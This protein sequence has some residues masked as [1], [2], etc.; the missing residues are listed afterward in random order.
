M[1]KQ[2]RNSSVRKGA[3]S[4]EQL[5]HQINSVGVE[6]T[7]SLDARG[8]ATWEKGEIFQRHEKGPMFTLP[9]IATAPWPHR[10]ISK[11]KAE[12]LGRQNC[13]KGRWPA[14]GTEPGF[15]TER[16]KP[17]FMRW[18]SVLYP[19]QAWGFNFLKIRWAFIWIPQNSPP[20]CLL[21]SHM[22][23]IGSKPFSLKWTR[24]Y[25]SRYD[26]SEIHPWLANH[27][28]LLLGR[29]KKVHSTWFHLDEVY[30]QA[31]LSYGDRNQK[32]HYPCR[33]CGR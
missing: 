14:V 20:L 27:S 3:L 25:L 9:F 21:S 29:H 17:Y 4:R 10:W 7:G 11:G 13:W 26:V 8:W 23:S 28:L 1:W 6:R 33:V 15:S 24:V 32:S 19:A 30:E 5:S 12:L 2:V 18:L 22:Y 16:T 31:K